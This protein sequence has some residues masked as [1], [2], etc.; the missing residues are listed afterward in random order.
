MLATCRHLASA[1]R[2]EC[3]RGA[4][5]SS[6]LSAHGRELGVPLE[7]LVGLVEQVSVALGVLPSIATDRTRRFTRLKGRSA[8]AWRGRPSVMGDLV[9]DLEVTLG[10]ERHHHAHVAR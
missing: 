6:A 4:L 3:G 10:G 5:A 8:D 9:D 1:E 7:I 2:R